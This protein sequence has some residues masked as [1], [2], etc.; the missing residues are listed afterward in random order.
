MSILQ[1]S[2]RLQFYYETVG[3]EEIE[4]M[5]SDLHPIVTYQ[6]FLLLCERNTT[7]DELDA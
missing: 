4:T 5:L 6:E 7:L 3:N 2:H 1:C